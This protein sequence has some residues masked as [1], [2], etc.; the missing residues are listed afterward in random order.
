MN[1]LL[2]IFRHVVV[3]K[4]AA[5]FTAF[6]FHECLINNMIFNIQHEVV[7]KKLPFWCFSGSLA[8]MGCSRELAQ[9]LLNE[10]TEEV[11]A[12]MV[13]LSIVVDGIFT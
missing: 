4:R 3:P 12:Q 10:P 13:H 9:Q 1:E 7:V 8:L 11:K 2:N 6:P 5:V